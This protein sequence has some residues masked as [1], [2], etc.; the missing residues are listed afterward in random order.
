MPFL[1]IPSHVPSG[2]PS[3]LPEVRE[4]STRLGCWPQHADLVA[5]DS[6]SLIIASVWQLPVHHI[7]RA[8][9]F[10]SAMAAA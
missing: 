5:G 10:S 2:S 1:K 8:T 6:G 7:E 9:N 3:S 4:R